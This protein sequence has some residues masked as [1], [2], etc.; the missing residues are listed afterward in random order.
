MKFYLI[1]AKGSKTGMPIEINVDLFL[2]G[3]D[4]MCQL[5]NANLGGKHCALVNREKKVFIRDFQSGEATVVNGQVLPSGEEWPLHAGDRIEVGNLA[6]VIQFRE[7]ALSQKDLEEWAASCLDLN[8]QRDILAEPVTYE[9]AHSASDAASQIIDQLNV[10]KGVVKGRLRIS[11]EQGIAITRLNDAMLVEE[12]EVSHVKKELT[13]NLNKPNLRVLLDLKNVRRLSTN[14]VVMLTE[15][16]RWLRRN[17][18]SL[19]M[20]R[21]RPELK[22]IMDTMHIENIPIFTDK[23]AAIAGKW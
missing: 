7:K 11:R 22:E 2:I 18:G 9:K 14:A 8:S 13:D 3:S 23:A 5:K 19:S 4:K 16:N 6:F 1:V 17:G 21:V 12:A 10:L 15:F 20:C